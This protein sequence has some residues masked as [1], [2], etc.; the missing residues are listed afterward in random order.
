MQQDKPKQQIKPEN[1]EEKKNEPV[2]E[3]TL[4]QLDSDGMTL[5]DENGIAG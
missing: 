4:Q 1:L 3:E 5:L 2:A